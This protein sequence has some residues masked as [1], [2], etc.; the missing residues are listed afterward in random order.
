M[1]ICIYDYD[2]KP[3]NVVHLTTLP[4]ASNAAIRTSV[5]QK[6]TNI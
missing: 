4:H 1:Y 6:M 3:K 2:K 5:Q